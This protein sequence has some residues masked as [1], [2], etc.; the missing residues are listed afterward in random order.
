MTAITVGI[1]NEFSNLDYNWVLRGM[2]RTIL[3][4][5]YTNGQKSQNT[6]AQRLW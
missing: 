1:I 6:D 2:S 3:R 5:K 4:K